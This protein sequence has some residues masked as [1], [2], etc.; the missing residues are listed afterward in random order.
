MDPLK[1]QQLTIPTVEV[2]LSIEEQILIN[3]AKRLKSHRNLL[4]N[5]IEA[6][7]LQKLSQL[8]SLTQSNIVAIAKHSGL[9][10]NEVS[11]MLEKAGYSAVNQYEGDLVHA[12]QAGM[13]VA[14]APV[15]E[16]AA[17]IGVLAS[18]QA[19][20]KDVFNLINTTL[21]S[22]AKQVYLDIINSTVGKVLSGVAT[23]YQA[24]RETASKWAEKGIPSLID[25]AG[26]KWSTEGY[27][28]MITRT[29]S[30]N[31]ANEMQFSRM[32]E[33][34]ADLI[35]VSSHMGAR[36]RCAPFQGKIYSRSGNHKKYPP[37]SSTSY[38]EAAGLKGVNCG[39]IFYPFIEGISERRYRPIEKQ[40][41]SD[42]YKLSQKQ[43]YLERRI[44][45][46]KRELNMMSTMGDDIGID[47]ANKK[48]KLRQAD[49]R[50]FISDT[51][52]TRRRNREQVV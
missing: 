30:N 42:A 5:D 13:L 17:L 45:N 14:P 8:E 41:N 36:P 51:G 15:V 10:I 40:E 16:S 29:M 2:F 28:N 38:G 11:K 50:A 32:D 1:S 43:R 49:M 25:K 12:V 35:E 24:L 19:Q 37:L 39:H 9:A 46:A 34:G 23:P 48:V 52:R 6:W 47:I 21:L 7:Q 22:Q 4:E 33:Y 31:I 26:R 20:A 18:F 44:R 27:V 3:I